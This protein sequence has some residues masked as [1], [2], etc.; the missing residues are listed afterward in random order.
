MCTAVAR[1]DELGPMGRTR[2][3]P[4]DA[5]VYGTRF[6]GCHGRGQR[7]V[8]GRHTRRH[9]TELRTKG[10]LEDAS[11]LLRESCQGES[12]M[13]VGVSTVVAYASA[14]ACRAS[15]DEGGGRREEEGCRGYAYGREA[16]QVRK[17][18]R[19]VI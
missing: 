11:P 2:R 16:K 13:G 8:D 19:T 10:A 15:V 6:C 12:G 1:Q 3:V 5:M 9:I 17:E 14:C 4:K 18:R 7:H